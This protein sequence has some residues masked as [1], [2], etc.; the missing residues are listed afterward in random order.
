[1]ITF[2]VQNKH[3]GMEEVC[4]FLRPF[5]NYSIIRMPASATFH[6]FVRNLVSSM[7]SVCCSFPTEAIPVIKLLMGRVKYFPCQ[8]AEVSNSYF[9]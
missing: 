3:L 5:L 1:M 9:Q 8:K 2:V 4:E 6:S 7:A